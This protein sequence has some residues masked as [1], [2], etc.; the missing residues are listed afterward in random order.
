MDH[1]CPWLANCVGLHNYKAF[2]LF[3]I[4][5]SLFCILCCAVASAWVWRELLSDVEYTQS[6][7]PIN[8]V[9]LAVIAGVIGLV[10]SGF[11][12]N[13]RVFR[14]N[15]IPFAATETNTSC[16]PCTVP[17]ECRERLRKPVTGSH[18]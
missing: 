13:D 6:L 11:T 4:Y 10:L 5:T 7:M 14:E 9:M 8:Y 16:D 2:L 17:R 1:H 15:K 18:E 3:L 12:D